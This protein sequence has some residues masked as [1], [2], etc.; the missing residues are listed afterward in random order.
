MK[1]LILSAGQGSRLL[2]LTEDRPK[3]LLPLDE[4]GSVIEWQIRELVKCGIDEVV[5]VLGF[6][7]E[8]VEDLLRKLARPGLA[9][10]TIYNPF[11]KLADNL[12]SCWLARH[13]MDRDF[14]V[15]NGDTV[16]EAA[17]PERLL[18][19]ARAPITVTIDRKADYDPD[20]M[21]VVVEG[22]RLLDI[23]KTLALD[24][25]NGESIGMLLFRGEGPRLFAGAVERAMRTPEGLKWWYLRVIA[26]LARDELV[27]TVS[28]EGLDWGEID[29]PTDLQHVQRMVAG[30]KQGR[31]QRPQLRAVP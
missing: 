16:F 18:S 15:V 1:A 24:T 19:T 17:I 28:I 12:G 27:G 11:F 3:C 10:R 29:Y 25:V 20:D 8:Q 13:E 21:K 4:T 14:L 22:G 9:I 7:A 26:L 31:R 30:W 2:P 6:H 23:G 5:V